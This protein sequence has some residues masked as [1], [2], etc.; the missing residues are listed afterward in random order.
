VELH[1]AYVLSFTPAAAPAGYHRLRVEVDL[2]GAIAHT[3][4]GYWLTTE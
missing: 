2:A 3:R 1:S 4:P